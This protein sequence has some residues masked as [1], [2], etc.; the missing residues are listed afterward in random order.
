MAGGGGVGRPGTGR[1]GWRR[2]RLDRDDDDRDFDALHVL[3]ATGS[4]DW[5]SVGDL[6]GSCVWWIHTS[7]PDQH[8]RHSCSC[9]HLPGWGD[10]GQKRPGKEGVADQPLRVRGGRPDLHHHPDRGR[11]AACCHRSEV[12]RPRVHAALHFFPDPDRGCVGTQPAQGAAERGH[13]CPDRLCGH[14]SCLRGAALCLWGDRLSGWHPART[15]VDR[16][17]CAGRS[18]GPCQQACSSASH[19]H[20]ACGGPCA[21][22]EGIQAMSAHHFPFYGDWHHYWRPTRPGRRNRLLDRVWNRE[23]TLQTTRKIWQGFSR[24]TCSG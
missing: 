10:D 11:C 5:L 2:T 15:L 8:A 16:D 20:S 14:G 3:F 17:V 1:G 6:Q 12:F 13:R 7:H 19:T 9:G 18:A 22:R 24:R 23:K 21:D 4:I